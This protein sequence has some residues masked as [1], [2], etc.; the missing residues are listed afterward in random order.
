MH[1][2][3]LGCQKSIVPRTP[4]ECLYEHLCTA[5][6][7]GTLCSHV[8]ALACIGMLWISKLRTML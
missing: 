3:F 4:R 2:R 6:S 8:M 1:A 5:L 7:L